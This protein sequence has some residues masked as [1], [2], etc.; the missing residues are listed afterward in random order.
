MKSDIL[1]I[2]GFHTN[3]LRQTNMQKDEFVYEQC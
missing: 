3:S 2:G 1:I